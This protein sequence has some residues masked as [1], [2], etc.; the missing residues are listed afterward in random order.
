M[1]VEFIGIAHT[2]EVSETIAPV[3]P[4]VQPDYL[5]RLALAHEHS[6]STGCWSRQFGLARRI[7]RR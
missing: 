2:N 7:H 6:G 5:Y 1:P 3:G 4:V